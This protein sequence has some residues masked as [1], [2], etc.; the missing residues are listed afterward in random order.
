MECHEGID[1]RSKCAGHKKSAAWNVP[2]MGNMPFFLDLQPAQASVQFPNNVKL[3]LCE[4]LIFAL[5]K[6]SLHVCLGQ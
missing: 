2:V 4:L 5:F 3:N 1:G 6:V